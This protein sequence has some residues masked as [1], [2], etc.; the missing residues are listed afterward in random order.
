MAGRFK[1]AFPYY[2]NQ[3]LH[4]ACANKLNNSFLG[5][6][7]AN[8]TEQGT[9]DDARRTELNLCAA[10]NT[11]SRFPRYLQMNTVGIYAQSVLNCLLTVDVHFTGCGRKAWA[12][13]RVQHSHVAHTAGA[14]LHRALGCRQRR[15]CECI[16]F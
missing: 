11:V 6:V 7:V 8:E 3:C 12:V 13:W 4:P 1:G 16:L 15:S 10:C 14:G 9:G 2:Y 5:C